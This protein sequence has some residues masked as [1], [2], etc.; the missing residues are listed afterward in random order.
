MAE[1]FN[2][3]VP[4]EEWLDVGFQVRRPNDPFDQLIGDLLER[5]ERSR[6]SDLLPLARERFALRP[7]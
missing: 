6:L 5:Q 7:E 4:Q 3:L 1:T 2:G